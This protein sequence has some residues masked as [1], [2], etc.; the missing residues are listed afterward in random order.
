M[1]TGCPASTVLCRIPGPGGADVATCLRGFVSPGPGIQPHDSSTSRFTAALEVAN[2]FQPD[3]CKGGF[4]S[5]P[6]EPDPRSEGSTY[7]TW[8]KKQV[9][10]EA[11]IGRGGDASIQVFK[12]W[13][14]GKHVLDG[15][16]DSWRSHVRPST[17]HQPSLQRLVL[18]G[19]ECKY[20]L[21]PSWLLWALTGPSD[22]SPGRSGGAYAFA[23][24]VRP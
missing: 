17:S 3:S 15:W 7:W 13:T 11:R 14:R 4:R 21:T 1:L 18:F 23:R 12:H 16:A 24:A 2:T 20:D 19:S 22:Q 5:I 8:G 9:L 10:K 6:R